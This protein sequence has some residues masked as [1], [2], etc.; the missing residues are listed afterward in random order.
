MEDERYTGKQRI[1]K[2]LDTMFRESGFKGDASIPFLINK[3]NNL[4]ADR[5]EE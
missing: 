3:L 4:Y 1:P 2:A 5:I